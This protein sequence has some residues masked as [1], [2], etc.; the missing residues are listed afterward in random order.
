M[1]VQDARSSRLG[2]ALA[3]CSLLLGAAI[4]GGCDAPEGAA[5]GPA[6]YET[7]SACHGVDGAGMEEFAAPSIA[8]L[9]Q[10]YLEAQLEKF[11]SGARGAHAEDVNGL[12]MRGMAR[13]LNREGDVEAV[14]AHV[15]SMPAALNPPTLDGNASHGAELYAPCVE[16]HGADGAGNEERDAP[17]I[18]QL[19]DWYIV[20]QLGLFKQGIRGTN[21]ADA[22]GQ[23]MRPMTLALAN[24]QDMADLAAHIATL[25]GR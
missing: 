24:E 13:T 21:E 7:C 4:A 10:W 5:R 9:P 1:V 17:P 14:A 15:A 20:A 12:R 3:G 23:T 22:S 16:C 25:R 2:A 18:R 11:Q 6:L 19:D 8:G